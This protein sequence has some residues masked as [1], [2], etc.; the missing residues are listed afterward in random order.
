[1][2]LANAATLVFDLLVEPKV[3]SLAK[4]LLSPALGLPAFHLLPGSIW[5]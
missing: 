2:V 1:V 5:L 4:I 3:R